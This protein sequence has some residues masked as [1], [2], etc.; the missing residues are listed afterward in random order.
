MLAC[1]IVN[2]TWRDEIAMIIERKQFTKQ[3]KDA[4]EQFSVCGI[5][6]PRQ[7]G[8][9]TLAHDF[10]K[11]NFEKV[12]LFDLEDP[13]HLDQLQN[14]KA[15][16]DP[17]SGLIIIDEIQRKPDLFP[18]L[19][20]LSDYS[21]KKFLILG[22]ASVDLLRQA[23]ESL[24]GRIDYL[25]LTPFNV[26]EVEDLQ[27][28]WCQGGFPR[29]YLATSYTNSLKWRKNYVSGFIERDLRSIEIQLNAATMR[30]LWML[31]AHY[32]GQILNYSDIGR[33]LGTS[34]MTIRRYINILSQTF[35]IRLLQP[36]HENIS[37]RQIKA[38]KIYMR[39][40][41]LLHATLNIQENDWYAH[42]VRGASFEGYIIEE[43]IRKFGQE[44]EY[45]F[46][47]THTGDELDLLV[48]KDGKRYGFEVKLADAPEVTKSMHVALNDLKLEHLYIVTMSD[49]IYQ[50]VDK[51]SVLGAKCI[52]DWKGCDA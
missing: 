24:T 25:E 18:Y 35:M 49:R 8:K 40:T 11:A 47:R 10:S 7:C 52:A 9:T 27:K 42:P 19:R 51:I 5:L 44:C 23:S 26:G 22:S 37:K 16:L 12:Y 21:D 46:W 34:D 3:I 38:P 15:A 39:D 17:L 48:I 32:H 30:Q 43:L 45:Y 6:G 1:V 2:S 20:V 41:G 28:H 33:S 13:S 50:K 31:I 4:F 14:P 36:W 29:S